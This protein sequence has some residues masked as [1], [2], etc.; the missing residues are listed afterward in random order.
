MAGMLSVMQPLLCFP[1]PDSFAPEDQS[2]S[3]FRTDKMSLYFGAEGS[4]Y[5]FGYGAGRKDKKASV[6]GD[7]PSTSRQADDQV[8]NSRMRSTSFSSKATPPPTTTP[9]VISSVT[10]ALSADLGSL[11]SSAPSNDSLPTVQ[12]GDTQSLERFVLSQH[13]ALKEGRSKNQYHLIR[14]VPR[15]IFDRLDETGLVGAR[16]EY[17]FE[18]GDLIVKLMPGQAYELSHIDLLKTIETK[19]TTMGVDRRALTSTG[20]TTFRGSTRAKQGD[21]G[22]KPYPV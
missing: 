4:S 14:G 15:A 19:L 17:D 16:M 7:S 6:A 18:T 13:T 12:Y 2:R 5:A 11:H 20:N 22:L 8:E 1:P 3:F 21:G 9:S 10:S